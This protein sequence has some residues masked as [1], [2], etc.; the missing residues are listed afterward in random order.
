MGGVRRE[1]EKGRKRG[2]EGEER[3]MWE[4]GGKEGRKEVGREK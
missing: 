4:E 1:E 3:E 2:G